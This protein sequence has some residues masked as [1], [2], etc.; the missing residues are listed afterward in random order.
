[1]KKRFVVGGLI[2]MAVFIA[3]GCWATTG[4]VIKEVSKAKDEINKEQTKQLDEKIAKVDKK[5]EDIDKKLEGEYTQKMT[6]LQ[7]ELYTFRQ[8][9]TKSLEEKELALKKAIDGIKEWIDNFKLSNKDDITQLSQNLTT[10]INVFM[11]KLEAEK[12]GIERAILEL[13]KFSE[14]T[15]EGGPETPPGNK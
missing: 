7:S 2:I 8:E 3:N 9:I 10:T 1:M 6:G 15:P 11:K 13:K 5:A 12:E 4:S 14:T